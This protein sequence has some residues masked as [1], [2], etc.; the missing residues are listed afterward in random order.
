VIDPCAGSAST[1]RAA[2]ECG[3]NSYGFEVNTKFFNEASQKMVPS[4]ISAQMDMF[5]GSRDV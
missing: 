4:T 3:R 2:F 1:L 5:G